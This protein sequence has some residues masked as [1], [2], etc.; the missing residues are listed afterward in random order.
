M[1][2]EPKKHQIFSCGFEHDIFV[3]EPYNNDNSTYK[4]KGHN[5]SV[6][7]L[8]INPELNELISMDVIGIIKIWDTNNYVN[9]QT[10]NTN[11]MLLLIQNRIKNKN[12]INITN[13]KRLSSNNSSEILIS[14]KYLQLIALPDKIYS[15]KYLESGSSILTV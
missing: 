12:G 4:L 9:F 8:V 11:D 15:N 13:K 1:V 2:Y 10:I 3:Y 14:T 5:S 6:N 7:S